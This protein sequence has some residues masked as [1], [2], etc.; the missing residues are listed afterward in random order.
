MN[1]QFKIDVITLFTCLFSIRALIKATPV[2][3][4]LV[5]ITMTALA[6]RIWLVSRKKAEREA[7]DNRLKAIE[8]QLSTLQTAITIKRSY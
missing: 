3:A 2:D 8:A 7:L 6:I 4:A 1:R 5:L